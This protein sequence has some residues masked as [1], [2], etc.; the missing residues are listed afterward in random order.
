MKKP[1]VA[2]V[3]YVNDPADP[4]IDLDKDLFMHALAAR[5]LDAS[6]AVWNDPEVDWA[7][8]DLALVRSTWDYARQRDAFLAWARS[9]SAVTRLENPFEILEENTDKKYLRKLADNGIPVIPSLFLDS[10]ADLKKV[11]PDAKAGWVV[12]PT[13]GAGA[14]G[15][16]RQL[17]WDGVIRAVGSHF[18]KSRVPLMLQPYLAEVDTSG[19]I[20]VM[21]CRG[22][23][24]HA[25]IKRPA[26]SE[27]GHGDF[28]G[29]AEITDELRDFVK[30]VLA[31]PAAR[32]A[33]ADLLYARVDVVPRDGGF[34]LMELEAT[35]P[36][37]FL[38]ACEKAAGV[39]A[40][41][42]AAL[43]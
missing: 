27:W 11:F 24:T 41:A 39:F 35:E 18:E 38:P 2:Y 37:L 28:A 1:R 10:P 4:D 40:G 34:M 8:F 43:F 12:K 29:T 32:G 19:E 30:K 16:S 42:V 20:A 15:A 13:I 25:V 14:R 22:E 26:L 33:Y 31:Q 17:T 9:V 6:A 5:G 36:F 21:C 3:T 23:P 7:S